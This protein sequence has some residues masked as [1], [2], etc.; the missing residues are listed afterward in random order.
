M[1]SRALAVIG[2]SGD[3]GNGIVRSAVHRGWNVTAVSRTAARL[4]T[5]AREHGESL[6]TVVGDIGSDKAGAELAAQLGPVDAIVVSISPP[7]TPRDILEWSADEL[8]AFVAGNVGA[9]LVAARHL[10]PL[11]RAGGEYLGI[12]GGMA[13]L[14]IPRYIPMAIVQ[15]AQRQL[16]RGIIREARGG[17]PVRIRE[18]LVAAFVNGPATR[19][20]ARPDWITDDEIG[21]YVLDLFGQPVDSDPAEQILLLRSPRYQPAAR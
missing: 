16:Y 14:V 21:D 15:A 3:V 10:L 2:A 17:L 12:G 13:D 18:L 6:R 8:N 5:L 4:G 11:V 7:F 1:Q 19:E 9:H 20:I